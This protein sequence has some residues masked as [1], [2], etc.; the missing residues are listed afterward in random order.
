[1]RGTSMYTLCV[2]ITNTLYTDSAFTEP[3][4]LD[5]ICIRPVCEL[6]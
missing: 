1:M 5:A 6:L 4:K 3:F 2:N